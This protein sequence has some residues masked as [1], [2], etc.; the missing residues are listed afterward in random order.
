GGAMA[1]AKLA[2]PLLKDVQKL[3]SSDKP[4]DLARSP[5]GHLLTKEVSPTTPPATH[6]DLRRAL[7]GR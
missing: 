1:A 7:L 4:E 6:D 3:V 5:L 2:I